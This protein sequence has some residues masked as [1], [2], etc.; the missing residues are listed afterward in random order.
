MAKTDYLDILTQEY[1]ELNEVIMS[2]SRPSMTR[3][4]F[5]DRAT[6]LAK[7]YRDMAEILEAYVEEILIQQHVE[8]LTE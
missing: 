6:D 1:R 7:E 8:G 2:R 3:E 5:K 4:E